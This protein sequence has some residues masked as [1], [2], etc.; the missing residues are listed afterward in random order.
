[1]I[2]SG[3]L[4]SSKQKWLIP[5]ICNLLV[6]KV[7]RNESLPNIIREGLF[8]Q[9]RV[10]SI[11]VEDYVERILKFC[12]IEGST[13]VLALIYLDRVC[14]KQRFTL[15]LNNFHILFLM[16]IVMALI[17]NEDVIYKNEYFAKIGGIP[18]QKFGIYQKCFL[19]MINFKLFVG[20]NEYESYFRYI[21]ENLH[22]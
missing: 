7:D 17:Y 9:K 20:K 6:S 18:F 21:D 19:E 8:F 22:C 4:I 5:S 11:G 16:A 13:L 3:L 1:M 15:N 10:P 14:K 2:Q 12:V